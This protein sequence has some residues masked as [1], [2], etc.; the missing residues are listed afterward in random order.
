MRDTDDRTDE[1]EAPA[2]TGAPAIWIGPRAVVRVLFH[3]NFSPYFFGNFLSMCGT[4]FQN[5]AQ[6]ILIY[7]LTGSA[8]LVGVVNFALF[9]GVFLMAPWSGSAADRYD[10]R[11]LLALTQLIA[12]GITGCLALL[13]HLEMA[14]TSVVIG[15]A[16]LLGLSTAFA[17]PAR[18][19]LIAALVDR[20]DLPAAVSLNSVTFNL[21][22]AIGPVV[23]AFV[24]TQ[25]GVAPAFA[26]NSL[27]FLALVAALYLVHPKPQPARP[28]QNPRLIETIKLVWHD[29]RLLTLFAV[30]AIVSVASDPVSTLMPAFAT[31][32][33]GRPDTVAGYLI[34]TFGA[35]AVAAAF[36]F[37]GRTV[38]SYRRLGYTLAL[39]GAGIGGLALT[40][41]LATGTVALF[42][43]G[44]GFLAT[45]TTAT[46]TVQLEIDD[47]HRG[48]VMALWSIAFLGMRPP[49]SLIDGAV[50][51]V[52]GVRMGALLMALPAL[53]GGIVLSLSH[54]SPID[55]VRT[56]AGAQNR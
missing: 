36:F 7:R 52:A 31:R 46:A 23:A 1:I 6:T 22:R 12:A 8:F 45:V 16:L 30:V 27:S 17:I 56:R 39:L 18:Q 33:Y 24:V 25:F 20:E 34:G 13:A 32:A 26:F 41:T 43:G 42:I 3:R 54:R 40:A 48:R 19:A 14:G 55:R 11:R 21:A 51:S 44:F 9:A 15:L 29:S 38:H 53:A 49:A 28:D 37:A 4:W 2:E 47:A 35:G 50:A 5:L 10:R